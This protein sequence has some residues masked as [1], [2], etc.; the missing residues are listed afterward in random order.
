MKKGVIQR[1]NH[2]KFKLT[3]IYK[4]KIGYFIFLSLF[5]CIMFFYMKTDSIFPYFIFIASILNLLL[6]HR[7]P[8]YSLY[9]DKK[10]IT[11][12]ELNGYSKQ[13]QNWL[14]QEYPNSKLSFHFI[15]IKKKHVVFSLN[16]SSIHKIEQNE[17]VKFNLQT[18]KEI[19]SKLESEFN[20]IIGNNFPF[21]IE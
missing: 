9:V 13:V 14:N 4:L 2:V 18:K 1:M 15:D 5:I 21:I 7:K 8:K 20:T 10:N 17:F 12:K 6:Y 11:E 3:K 19:I 16:Y